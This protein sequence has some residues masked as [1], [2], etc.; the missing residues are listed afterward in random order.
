MKFRGTSI[1]GN[2]H[3]IPLQVGRMVEAGEDLT[4]ADAE[5]EDGDVVFFSRFNNGDLYKP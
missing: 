2:L 4:A 1:Y 5:I 3:G